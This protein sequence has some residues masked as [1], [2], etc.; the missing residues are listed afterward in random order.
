M[1]ARR[2]SRKAAPAVRTL[3]DLLPKVAAGE[4]LT[5]REAEAAFSFLMTGDA[6]PAQMGAFLMALRV[7]G[8]TVDEIAGAA[9]VLR[10]RAE[11]VIAPKGAVDTCG[12]GGDASGTFNISTAAALVVAACGVPVAKHGNRA[13]SSR[14]GSADL[15]T[16]AGVNLEAPLEVVMEGMH[17]LNFGFLMA[18]RHHLATRN[19]APVRTELGTRTIFNLLGPLS[20]PALAK[21]Q[22]LGVFDKRWVEPVAQ[23]L[24]RLGSTR[25]WVVHGSDGLDEITTTGITHVAELKNRRVR[26]FTVRPEQASLKR[27][28]LS[29]LAGGT[30]RQNARRLG[31]LLRGETGPI[32]DIVLL[33]AAAALIV[34]DR[35]TS[36]AEGVKLA[37]TAIDDGSGQRL[38]RELVRLTQAPARQDNTGADDGDERQETP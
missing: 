25:A 16:A 28:K 24:H 2:G 31:R 23:V 21:R 19:V 22:V 7:R 37:A 33:N 36:L 15:L 34:A 6:T 32:R 20:S 30:P 8:E 29:D 10:E 14:S 4:T 12:T 26:A 13:I 5:E 17:R 18:P 38:L 3:K 27:A 35:A 1:A 9:R 11:R